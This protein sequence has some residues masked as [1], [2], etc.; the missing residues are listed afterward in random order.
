NPTLTRYG[1]IGTAPLHP[2]VAISF[3]VL[4]AYRA[5]HHASP[6]FSIQA[7]V[8]ALCKLHAILYQPYLCTQFRITYDI[9]LDIL[10]GVDDLVNSALGRNT[11]QWHMH[12]ACAPCL[13]SIEGEE[14]LTP[15]LL[16]TMDG[17]QSL[18]LVDD[19]YR[20]G[21]TR[22]DPRT[23]RTDMW[24]SP[25]DVD[26]F[27]DEVRKQDVSPSNNM[28]W[29]D[30]NDND[31][32]VSPVSICEERWRNAGPEARKKMFALFAITGIFVAICRHG[33][34][35]IMCDMIRSGELMKYPLAIVS[36]LIDVYGNDI[37]LGYDIACSF[38][39]T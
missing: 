36:K 38:A 4:K 2:S 28:V 23:A 13:Y 11:P 24:L 1:Y 20:A 15:A 35:L 31:T 14:P 22:Y 21:T 16:A 18:K 19:V 32:L 8:K 37:K 3:D 5:Q 27:K 25:E 30:I 12:N 33:Q 9:Y 6:R 39:K 17:N 29:L 34:L 26:V 7:Q 10:Y